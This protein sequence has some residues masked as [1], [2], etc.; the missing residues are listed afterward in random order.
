M[1]FSMSAA[2]ALIA[3][4]KLRLADPEL[5][6]KAILTKLREQEPACDLGA[7]EVREMLRSLDE[8]ASADASAVDAKGAG[9]LDDC[10]RIALSEFWRSELD[11]DR[12]RVKIHGLK[13]HPEYNGREGR[14]C[15]FEENC[16]TFMVKLDSDRREQEVRTS[17]D[18]YNIVHLGEDCF[19]LGNVQELLGF[20]PTSIIEGMHLMAEGEARIRS[21]FDKFPSTFQ[22]I[23]RPCPRSRCCELHASWKALHPWSCA[24]VVRPG[25]EG[26]TPAFLALTHMDPAAAKRFVLEGVEPPTLGMACNSLF[27]W[28]IKTGHPGFAAWL[29][30][31]PTAVRFREPQHL[32]APNA[33][34]QTPLHHACS[35]GYTELVK[36]L[37][38]REAPIEAGDEDAFTPLMAAVT[39]PGSMNAARAILRALADRGPEQVAA[40]LSRTNDRGETALCHAALPR[41]PP[42]THAQQFVALL[43]EHGAS[44]LPTCRRIDSGGGG[45]CACQAF[46][47]KTQSCLRPHVLPLAEEMQTEARD[48]R[49]C[50]WCQIPVPCALRCTKCRKVFYCS[51]DCQKSH[52]KG[53]HKA[54]CKTTH[55]EKLEG[56]HQSV[57]T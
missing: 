23:R 13:R 32:H 26:I 56:H 20:R 12:S 7:K 19:V 9:G 22:I 39:P 28:A 21:F 41:P 36:S 55:Q 31:E 37:I 2:Q 42:A 27:A 57:A 24:C 16:G 4:R 43:A 45:H 46:M 49:I 10:A 48:G 1:N 47:C 5:G 18:P 35:Q 44:F 29:L 53:G 52:W 3:L 51:T 50:A 38:I 54:A 14:L 40:A 6:V 8:D 34:G 15:G 33:F 30:E 17:V 25:N 11:N